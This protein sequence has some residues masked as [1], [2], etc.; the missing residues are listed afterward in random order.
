MFGNLTMVYG[1]SG[2]YMIK[3][4]KITKQY[5]ISAYTTDEHILIIGISLLQE[6]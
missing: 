2:Y 6:G 4:I 1:S 5:I 3:L